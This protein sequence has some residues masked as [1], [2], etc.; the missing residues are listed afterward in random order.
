MNITNITKISGEKVKLKDYDSKRE[1]YEITYKD[2]EGNTRTMQVYADSLKFKD[3]LDSYR[4]KLSKVLAVV[5][6]DIKPFFNRVKKRRNILAIPLYVYALAVIVFFCMQPPEIIAMPFLVSLFPVGG[7]LIAINEDIDYTINNVKNYVADENVVNSF[8]KVCKQLGYANKINSELAPTFKKLMVESEAEERTLEESRK[9][10]ETQLQKNEQKQSD[11]I[12]YL[13]LPEKERRRYYEMSKY[14]RVEKE[15]RPDVPSFMRE[16]TDYRIRRENNY[17]EFARR[18]FEHP[19]SN[20]NLERVNLKK[21]K[22]IERPV[23]TQRE[24]N[25]KKIFITK[26]DILRERELEENTMRR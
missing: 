3:M 10:A 17:R 6:K 18:E 13:K 5:K 14:R 4:D 24:E 21:I 16:E 19:K 9:K 11:Y 2:L 23:L 26:E 22:E 7:I 1:V 12:D 15:F 8:L 25:N 20:I